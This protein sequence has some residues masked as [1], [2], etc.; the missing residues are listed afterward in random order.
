[1][2]EFAI[3]MPFLVILLFGIF[4]F[5]YVFGQHLDVRHGAREGSRLASVNFAPTSEQGEARSAALVAEI[6]NGMS[7]V[8]ESTVSLA[9]DQA[10][11]VSQ[12]DFVVVT[13]QSEA[14][15]VTGF[16]SPVLSDLTLRSAVEMRV[17]AALEYS[18]PYE[19]TC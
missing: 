1:M 4:E 13:V 7:L 6:C 2:V 15:Q 9:S 19:G 17:E 16:F 11:A 5:G 3:V 12:G 14:E 8:T 18:I 10:P